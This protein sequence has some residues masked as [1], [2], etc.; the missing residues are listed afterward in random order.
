[1]AKRLKLLSIIIPICIL[2]LVAGIYFKLQKSQDNNSLKR[3]KAPQ[4]F[5]MGTGILDAKIKAA[6]SSRISGRIEKINVEQGDYVTKGQTLITLDNSQLKADFNLADATLK[7]TKLTT[8]KLKKDFDYSNAV[9]DN[10]LNKY[11]RLKKLVES[12]AVSRQQF[13]NSIEELKAAESKV[14]YAKYA[15]LESEQKMVEAEKNLEVKKTRVDDCYI[16]APFDGIIIRRNLDPGDVVVAGTSI[17]TIVSEKVLWIKSW[18]NESEFSKIELG[19]PAK[20]IF[21]TE[22]N[23]K[24][25]GEV[26]RIAKDVDNE[27]REFVVDVAIK[28]LPEKWAIGQRAEVYIDVKTL[29]NDKHESGN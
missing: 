21:R 9:Y 2:G 10:A 29:K 6:I 16:K 5:V 19:E 8:I 18:V 11:N 27:T 23:I 15:V 28:E 17:M 12:N 1:M 25:T 13:D 4:S 7:T 20:I 22:P 26:A 3:I 24:Y 14:E